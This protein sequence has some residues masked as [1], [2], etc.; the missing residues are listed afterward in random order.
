M[1]VIYFQVFRIAPAVIAVT[2]ASADT[3]TKKPDPVV[4]F[5]TL[6]PTPDAGI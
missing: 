3:R 2:S 1:R 5:P 4:S 6:E